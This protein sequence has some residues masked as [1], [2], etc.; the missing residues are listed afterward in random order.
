MFFHPL[1]IVFGPT[2]HTTTPELCTYYYCSV[3]A[4]LSSTVDMCL[5]LRFTHLLMSIVGVCVTVINRARCGCCRCSCLSVMQYPSPQQGCCNWKS[6]FEAHLRTTANWS[7]IFDLFGK[8]SRQRWD[9]EELIHRTSFRRQVEEFKSSQHFSGPRVKHSTL[10]AWLKHSCVQ[11][12]LVSDTL[13]LR[14]G[15][16]W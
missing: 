8:S 14:A 12:K 10:A 5:L 7:R 1:L 9:G 16:V 3:F 6:F 2:H 15:F 4:I 11:C 13:E